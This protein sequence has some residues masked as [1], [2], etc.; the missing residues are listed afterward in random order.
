MWIF[1]KHGFFSVVQ[2]SYCK[3]GQL[4]VRAR[5]KKDLE[6]MLDWLKLK[7]K[8]KTLY[9]ADYRYRVAIPRESWVKYCADMARYID[10]S[11]VKGTLA[12]TG[13]KRA[14]AMVK[15]WYALVELQHS[16]IVAGCSIKDACGGYPHDCTGCIEG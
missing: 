11:N 1:T 16:D 5:E 14:H 6:K 8:I 15:C 9:E 13:S 2:D 4:M 10:Y 12:E 7:R 3:P